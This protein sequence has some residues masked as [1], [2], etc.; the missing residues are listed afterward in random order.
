[1]KSNG[2]DVV[3]RKL[4]DMLV[5]AACTCIGGSEREEQPG[6][7]EGEPIRQRVLRRRRTCAQASEAAR[8][9]QVR[10]VS[11]G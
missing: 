11:C 8:Q 10:I 9:G 5:S 7:E 3:L 1:M 6:H 2:N 4:V